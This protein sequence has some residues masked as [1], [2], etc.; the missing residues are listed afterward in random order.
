VFSPFDQLVATEAAVRLEFVYRCQ[1]VILNQAFGA[2]EY[3]VADPDQGGHPYDVADNLGKA[4]V[5]IYD[6]AFADSSQHRKMVAGK[7]CNT[8]DLTFE[9]RALLREI[10]Q[11]FADKNY[12]T[13]GGL[14]L[15][16][17]QGPEKLKALYERLREVPL[18]HSS[19]ACGALFVEMGRGEKWRK[20][21]PRGIDFTRGEPVQ[22]SD[23]SKFLEARFNDAFFGADHSPP[24]SRFINPPES[25]AEIAGMR[26]ISK[27]IQSWR[28]HLVTQTGHLVDL[29][30]DLRRAIER[31]IHSGKPLDSLRVDIREAWRLSDFVERFS[32]SREEQSLREKVKDQIRRMSES[33]RIDGLPAKDELGQARLMCMDVDFLTGLYLK[34]LPGQEQSH[35]DR[36]KAFMS[37]ALGLQGFADL[38]PAGFSANLLTLPDEKARDSKRRELTAH[39]HQQMRKLLVAA[40]SKGDAALEG[41]I[42]VAGHHLG[43]MIPCL[44]EAADK[45]FLLNEKENPAPETKKVKPLPSD[46]EKRMYMTMGGSASG[47]SGLK[48]IAEGECEAGLSLVVAS[49]DDARSECERYW[50]YPA[51]DNHNDDYQAAEQFGNTLRDLITQRALEAGHHIYIDGSGIPYEGRHDKTTKLFKDHG[52]HISVLAAQA[53]LFV[54]DPQRRKALSS[55]GIAP[56]DALSRLGARQAKE[57]RGLNPKIVVDKHIK[58]PLASRNAARDHIVDRFMIQDVTS[59]DDKYTLSYVL[60]L[61]K[62]ETEKLAQ[63]QGVE[64]KRAL[65]DGNYVP[66][67]VTLPRNRDQDHLFNIKVI[68]ANLGDESYRVEIITDIEQYICMVEKGLLKR[69]A[70]GP[71]ALYDYN[72]HAD[73]EGLFQGPEGKLKILRDKRVGERVLDQYLPLSEGPGA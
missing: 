51:T 45:Q 6:Y 23:P 12:D 27:T 39:V 56:D 66:S 21:F 13:Q 50:L 47:K 72:V 63:L 15:T 62:E 19:L 37:E 25:K 58:F 71:E 11:N 49:L 24:S 54:H 60:T 73:L 65:L 43:A 64:L 52:Y 14:A 31:H 17:E 9:D 10:F 40:R 20:L 22:E 35:L 28:T 32:Q 2:E 34:P 67:W 55:Q 42:A 69:N 48:R 44:Y 38:V 61:G 36:L 5:R 57:L 4:F 3:S 8:R 70:I 29:T 18:H 7:A 59:P 46:A 68:R 16:P 33:D 41:L 1:V 53:P 30:D 26:F